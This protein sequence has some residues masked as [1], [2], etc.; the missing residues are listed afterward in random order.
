VNRM[1]SIVSTKPAMGQCAFVRATMSFGG[2]RGG[3]PHALHLAV[4]KRSLR[5]RED[6]DKVHPGEGSA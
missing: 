1:P 2:Q 4:L 6:E 3:Y 5:N